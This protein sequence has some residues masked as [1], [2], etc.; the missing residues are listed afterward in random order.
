MY[1]NGFEG[2][3]LAYLTRRFATSRSHFTFATI[4]GWKLSWMAKGS[5]GTDLAKV[6]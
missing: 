3:E 6:D 4:L 1:K 5:I 2:E